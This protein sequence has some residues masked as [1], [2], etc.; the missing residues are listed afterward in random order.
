MSGLTTHVLDAVTGGGAVGIAVTTRRRDAGSPDIRSVS[1]SVTDGNGR[2]TLLAPHE[3]PAGL[4]EIGF[5]TVA[6]LRKQGHAPFFDDVVVQ[7]RVTESGGSLH[8]P[9][10]LA[11]SAYSAYRGGSP[12]ANA[13]GLPPELAR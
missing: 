8:V 12:P 1:V 2:A 13:A 4:Y 3:F 7:V 10:V 5:A 6:Y 9:I 11:P